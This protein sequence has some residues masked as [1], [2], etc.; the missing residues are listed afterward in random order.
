L[1]QNVLD[2]QPRLYKLQKRLCLTN[3]PLVYQDLLWKSI[4]EQRIDHRK[5]GYAAFCLICGEFV[6]CAS[7]FQNSEE[8]SRHANEGYAGIGIFLLMQSTHL[9]VMRG[10]RACILPSLYLD[11]HGEVSF[12]TKKH[13][14]DNYCYF[15]IN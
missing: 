8:C 5:M 15:E 2:V 14:V 12:S 4:Q 10:D 9:L 11:Q 13:L 7:E 1:D 3:L 6:W